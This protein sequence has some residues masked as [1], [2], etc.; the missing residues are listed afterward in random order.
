MAPGS[1]QAK[2]YGRAVIHTISYAVTYGTNHDDLWVRPASAIANGRTLSYQVM[3]DYGLSITGR[4]WCALT[5]RNAAT[6]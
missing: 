5:L 2:I 3:T 1:T 6:T 4:L